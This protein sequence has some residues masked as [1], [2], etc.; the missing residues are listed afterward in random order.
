MNHSSKGFLS[1]LS[2]IGRRLVSKPLSELS[3][4][5]RIIQT[6]W[7]SAQLQ[8]QQR[9]HFEKIGRLALRGA[10]EGKL[11]EIGFER[12]QTKIERIERIL[13]RQELLLRSYQKR[14]D[15]R[16]VLKEDTDIHNKNLDPV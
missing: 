14:G 15:I 10:R 5:G 11:N 4:T 13:V 7:D 2:K 9:A 12:L 8:A 3:R 16:E 1:W 6:L